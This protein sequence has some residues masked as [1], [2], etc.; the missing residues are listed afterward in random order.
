MVVD[1]RTAHCGEAQ[2]MF[3]NF[4]LSVNAFLFIY[5]VL[6]GS[7]LLI[8]LLGSACAATSRCRA[9]NGYGQTY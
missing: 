6:V 7:G 3:L 9:L 8:G 1:I 5:A 2:L 4:D